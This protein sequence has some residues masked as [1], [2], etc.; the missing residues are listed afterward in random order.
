VPDPSTPEPGFGALTRKCRVDRRLTQ[1]QL[2]AATGLSVRG[3]S[4]IER[5]KTLHPRPGTVRLLAD[6]LRLDGAEREAYEAEARSAYWGTR[7]AGP[8]AD[9]V[10]AP[11]GPAELPPDPRGF[12]GRADGVALLDSL[13]PSA[14]APAAVLAICGPAGVGKTSLAVHWAHRVRHR[15]GGGQLHVALRGSSPAGLTPAAALGRLLRSLGVPP[16]QVPPD[17][18]G[19]AGLYRTL[20]AGRRLLVLLDDAR[21]AAQVSELLPTGPGSLALVTSRD[22]VGGLVAHHGAGRVRLSGLDPEEARSLLA[23]V[24]GRPAVD[25]DPAATAEFT[26]LCG[27][28]PLALRIAAANLAGRPGADLA[29]YC[30]E[31]RANRLAALDLDGEE[32]GVRAAYALSYQALPV[33]ERR[34]FRLLGTAPG[35]DV[36]LAAAAALA[37]TDPGSCRRLAVRLTSAHLIEHRPGDR[38]ALHDL[39]RIYAREE[40]DRVEDPAD[41]AAALDRYLDHQLA[42]L[43]D[44]AATAF[45]EAPLL[46][47]DDPRPGAATALPG[48]PPIPGNHP[49]PG[50][51]TAL[52][53]AAPIPG[54]DP[55]PGAATAFPGATVLPG[56]DRRAGPAGDREAA[57]AVIE[58]ERDNLVAAVVAATAQGRWRA[59]VRIA[60][61]LRDFYRL[62]PHLAE[63]AAVTTAGLVSAGRDGRPDGLASALLGTAALHL[64]R[65]R[66]RDAVVA[67][68]RAAGLAGTAGWTAGR[69]VAVAMVG[70]AHRLAGSLPDA[71]RE[72]ELART[73]HRDAGL[74]DGEAGVLDKL[75][76]LAHEQGLLAEAADCF[77]Q[78]LDLHVAAGCGPR[79]RADTLLALGDVNRSLGRLRDAAEQLTRALE[80]HRR[81]GDRAGEAYVL[82]C[83]AEVRRDTGDLDRAGALARD[84][85]TAAA[86]VGD[87][88]VEAQAVQTLATVALLRGRPQD[89]VSGH[90]RALATA[91]EL[92]HE[93]AA[94]EAL[95]GLARA[96]QAL[97]RRT[98]AR[99]HATD[100]R[101]RATAAGY[102]SLQREAADVLTGLGEG[103]RPQPVS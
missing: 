34:L 103:A 47:G 8:P 42:V 1:E 30:A 28:Q 24:L 81:I 43:R 38:L 6:G 33:P 36:S 94:V 89:A 64:A 73:L 20:T 60:D 17:L 95:V 62:R 29:G 91:V 88:R 77:G 53:G 70:N 35:H 54:G 13:E 26:R 78:A 55:G 59:A 74:P 65:D 97:G 84:A 92:G 10:P 25:A 52:P 12:V 68:G 96:H 83:L 40:S 49:R 58:A 21:D 99:T 32:D 7:G 5:G 69:A 9:A 87:R 16:D 79:H 18:P 39:L 67:G 45:P 90:G 19:A 63:W 44:A 75:G 50:A 46:P 4:D 41:R 48:A 61:A 31:L 3:I 11:A 100:A 72:L 37:G 57:L 80:L 27:H 101:R 71:E 98:L 93:Y 82:R 66:Y 15:Y 51:A 22:A 14:G 86:R 76:L 23:T 56:G 2:A 85:A 102:G